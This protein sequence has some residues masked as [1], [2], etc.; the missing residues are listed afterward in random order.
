MKDDPVDRELRFHI[1]QLTAKYIAQGM[2][3]REAR[4]KARRE[5]GGVQQ[6]KEECRDTRPTRWIDSTLQDLRFALRTL[7]R[8]PALAFTVIVTLALGIGANTSIFSVINGVLLRPLPY[9]QPDRLVTFFETTPQ[10]ARMSAAYLNYVDWRRMNRTCEEL[11]ALM[12]RDFNLTG[13]GRPERL[14]GRMISTFTVLGIQPLLGRGFTQEED[15]IGGRAVVAISESLWRRRFGGDPG[16]LG[17]ALT[18]NGSRYTVVAVLPS[19]FEFPY[20]LNSFTEDVA[21]P[22]AQVANEPMLSDRRFNPGTRVVGRLKPGVALPTAQADFTRIAAALVRQYPTNA[23]HG[24]KVTPLK[25][26]LVGQFGA[27]L[28]LLMG[29]VGFVLLI[30]CANVANLLLARATARETEIGMRSAL[31]ASRARIVRQML[32][33]CILL[34]LAGGLAGLLVASVATSAL[35]KSA[36]RILPRAGHIG[37][38]GRVLFFTLAAAVLTGVLFGLAPALRF[39]RSRTGDAGRGIVAGRNLFRDLL[40]VAQLALTLPLLVGGALL[41]R[42]LSNL[43]AVDPGFDP[44]NV[45]AMKISLSPAAASSGPSIRRAQRDLLKRLQGMPGVSSVAI[46]GDLPM[47]GDDAAAPIWPADKPAPND[48][49]QKPVT[50]LYSIS[51]DYLQAMKIPL[52]RGRF[53]DAHD[54]EQRRSVIVIDQDAATALFPGEDAVGKRVVVGLGVPSEV[55]GVVGHV[56]HAGLDDDVRG[57]FHL[58]AYYPLVQLPDQFLKMTVAGAE[59]IVVR[60]KYDPQAI[61][62]GLRQAVESV[63]PEDAVSDIRSMDEIVNGTLMIRH[64]LL[65]LLGIFSGLALVIAEV[66]IYGVISYS[67]SRRTREVG[68]RMALGAS[69]AH[70]L[71]LIVGQG[72]AL[73]VLGIVVGLGLSIFLTRFLARM[74]FGVATTDPLTF[75]AVGLALALVAVAAS[76]LPALRGARADPLVALRCE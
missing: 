75:A 30:A 59:T 76:F 9:S 23:G 11:A 42:T 56:K 54:D 47:S 8:N 4:S 35:A 65:A 55:I 61:A 1:D 64:F 7:R 15:R 46:A 43:Q 19:G 51:S 74:L 70:I 48:Q 58:Q 12:W 40:V 6:L 39:S 31:G 45:L 69:R 27:P 33:E 20:L 60:A 37:M 66:G 67:V 26:S 2:S 49:N 71:R 52:L 29:A 50:L 28:F 21:V 72:A 53:I 18:L 3:E 34:A 44:H 5:F 38:D 17:R 73:S 10:L 13:D 57:N 63:D 14:H 24:V 68:I 22:L 41:V 62:A 16:I 36:A 32:T 25:Q